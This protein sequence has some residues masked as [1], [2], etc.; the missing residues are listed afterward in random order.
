MLAVPS[1]WQVLL[2]ASGTHAGRMVD[3][4]GPGTGISIMLIA[5]VAAIKRQSFYIYINSI[6]LF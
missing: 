6:I 5:D 1:K 3:E 2:V 4:D